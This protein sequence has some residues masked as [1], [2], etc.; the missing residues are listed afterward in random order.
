MCDEDA[1]G[2]IRVEHFVALG[3]QFGQ[4]DE[5]SAATPG[6]RATF[7]CCVWPDPARAARHPPVLTAVPVPSGAPGSCLRAARSRSFRGG[8]G[9]L[10]S[11]GGA[12]A[13]PL[14]A[15]SPPALRAISRFPPFPVEPS[16]K[17]A[18]LSLSPG[19]RGASP[20]PR[21]SLDPSGTGTGRGSFRGLFLFRVLSALAEL[22][23]VGHWERSR[24]GAGRVWIVRDAAVQ[25]PQ[26]RP[27]MGWERG[28]HSPLPP[29]A[30]S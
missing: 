14:A 26:K 3:L 17:T 24:C 30:L 28:L 13:L 25:E 7:T 10:R 4:G 16:P 15:W 20:I 22:S 27:G 11:S 18:H 21:G 2:F 23:S 9:S 19:D 29:S 5:V 12:R 6:P 1:D 8:S